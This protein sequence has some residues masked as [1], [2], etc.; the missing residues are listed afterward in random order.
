[1]TSPLAAFLSLLALALLGLAAWLIQREAQRQLRENVRRVGILSR[2]PAVAVTEMASIR[3]PQQERMPR[4]R[5]AEFMIGYN[6]DLPQAR[7]I[8]WPVM[9]AISM[10]AGTAAYVAADFYLGAAFAVP[11]C[12]VA[13]LLCAR[14]L[15]KYQQDRYCKVLFHQLPDALGLILRAIRAGL[16]MHVALRTVASEMPSPTNEQFGLVMGEAGLGRPLEAAFFRLYQRTGLTEF[17]FLSVT[18][19]LQA[20]TGGSLAETIENLADVIR[21][22]VALEA[23]AK[24]LAAEP[25]TSAM[26]VMALPIVAGGGMTLTRPGYLS[27]F[28]STAT[29]FNLLMAGMMLM[30]LGYLIIQALIRRATTD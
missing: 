4:L 28:W 6:R 13:A 21:K 17:A 24:A 30:I 9:F 14:K 23:R 12:L 29:G 10:A 1:M 22:R 3:L 5:A 19:G 18:L 25:K 27:V 2:M 20:Q 15:L 26:I 7:T 11:C 16:P 8:P